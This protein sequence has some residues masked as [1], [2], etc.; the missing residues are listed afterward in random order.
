MKLN[1]VLLLLAAMVLSGVGWLS[2]AHA[3]KEKKDFTLYKMQGPDPYTLIFPVQVEGPGEIK[4]H[5]KILTSEKKKGVVRAILMR[6]GSKAM[7]DKAEYDGKSESLQLRYAVDSVELAKFKDYKVVLNNYSH[8]R[9]ATGE[10][11]LVY[12]GKNGPEPEAKPVY[13]DLAITDMSLNNA[14]QL[15]VEVSNLGH[16]RV[17]PLA[18]DKKPIDLM[19]Y[20]DGKSWG[21]IALKVLDPQKKLQ[22][23]GGKVTYTFNTFTVQGAEKVR[24]VIDPNNKLPEEN[25]TNNA[26]NKELKGSG[27]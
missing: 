25:K 15:Q 16:G 14:K 3:D 1:R 23:F 18:Y 9:N 22:S 24:A 11:L 19:I 4:I 10:V 2:V 5:V 6:N 17:S 20:R 21:G 26:M 12:N 27:Q 7:L 13:C 8:S